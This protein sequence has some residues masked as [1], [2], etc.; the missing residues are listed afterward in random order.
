MSALWHWLADPWSQTIMQ[1]AL[2]EVVLLGVSGAALGCWIVY[3]EASYS[4][5]SLPHAM[6]PGLVAAALVGAPLVVG[7]AAGLLVA[8]VA[9]AIV[10]RIPGIGADTGVAVVVTAL[11]GLGVL[12]ALAPDSPPGVQALLFGNVLA[13]TGRD[14]LVAAGLTV[15]ILAALWLL[16]ARLLVAGF[17]RGS[18]RALG[19]RPLAADLVVLVLLAAAVLVAVPALGNLLVVAV[20]VAPA[21]SARMLCR[22]MP[23]TMLMAAVLAVVAGVLGLYVSYHLRTAAGASI[24][25]LMVLSWLAV[26]ALRRL[27]E[28]EWSGSAAG[29]VR[30]RA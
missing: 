11:F 16:H 23:A 29:G 1:R 22:R 4:A 24:A 30:G 8:A 27:M 7:G 17:D 3:F 14:L 26:A 19:V 2:V 5:E 12:L 21:T 20:I 9:V 15:G 25:V 18:A 10:G 6:F 13:I 28:R